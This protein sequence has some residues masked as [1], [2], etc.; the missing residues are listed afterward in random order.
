MIQTIVPALCAVLLTLATTAMAAAPENSCRSCHEAPQ[1]MKELGFAHFTVNANEVRAQTKHTTAD[2]QHC[3]LGNPQAGSK[4]EAHKGLARLLVVRK[5][6]LATDQSPRSDAVA[7]G[8]NPANRLYIATTKD[9]K[10]TRD[11]SV[12]TIQWH[13]KRADNLALDF[14]AL[15]KTCGS[16]HARQFDEFLKSPMGAMSK[17]SQY[18][19]WTDPQRGPHN[20]GPWFDGNYDRMQAN[21][22]VPIPK[23]GHNVN[24]KVC[25]SC[26]TG[27]LDCHFNPQPKNPKNP[28]IG[29]HSF[30]KT[31]PSPSCYGNGR[32]NLCHAGPED[33]RR[34]AGYY[35]G[36]FS[37]PEGSEADVHVKAKVGCLDCHDSSKN[38]NR[39]GH[40]VVKRQAQDSCVRCHQQA[41]ASHAASLHKKL[42]C[43]ACHI[44]QVAGYQATYWGPGKLA[45]VDTPFFK[46]KGYQGTLAQPI[47]IKDQ[48]G[49]WI[50]VKPYPMAVANQKEVPFKL[51]LYWRYPATLP[52][53]QRTD[54]A[55]A[56]TGL[57][58]GMV[59]NNKA[60]TWIQLDK[61]SHKLGKARSCDSCHA[62]QLTG[63]QVQKATWTYDGPGAEPFKGSH[64]VVASRNSIKILDIQA[65][66][67]LTIEPG[68]TLSAIAPWAYLDVWEV[69]GDFSIPVPSDL[70][71][72]TALK[73]DL[74]QVRGKKIIH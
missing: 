35:G 61:L 59:G 51:G 10:Q 47:L 38:D 60:L 11:A 41:V 67:R 3:H 63:T 40:G 28:A 54:D 20:C 71:A 5:K 12:A 31:P 9:G 65:H 32:A 29:S 45:G 66:D 8:S 49:R 23:A 15:K 39:L 7:Y 21:T 46:Y 74:K 34:G 1:R 55:W 69:S 43:E 14:D 25:N 24:Q 18:A 56:F 70:A 22:G 4:E 52:D 48:Q 44:Q 50:P 26:H 17:Q 58:G 6:G 64:T 27:C 2:C 36:P 42:T 13:D 33:N 53:Y 72:Y 37:V 16:C 30:A 57:H 19:G 68:F 62:E 73:N